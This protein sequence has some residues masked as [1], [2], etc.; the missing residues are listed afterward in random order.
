MAHYIPHVEQY[1]YC[2]LYSSRGAVQVW[3]ALVALW[4]CA[5]YSSCV[6]RLNDAHD[7]KRDTVQLLGLDQC[8]V[9]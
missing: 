7:Y 3:P 2:A 6:S 8:K 9:T 5:L 4:Y 1:R